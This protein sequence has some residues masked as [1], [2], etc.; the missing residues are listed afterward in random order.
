MEF[1]V[2]VLNPT[3]LSYSN[4]ASQEWFLYYLQNQ[5]LS[6]RKIFVRHKYCFL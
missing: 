2:V 4:L 6:S 3:C 1:L 5:Y